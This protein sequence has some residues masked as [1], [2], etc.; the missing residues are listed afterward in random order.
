MPFKSKNYLLQFLVEI[1]LSENYTEIQD[2]NGTITT[3][4]GS[5]EPLYASPSGLTRYNL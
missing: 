1:A 2:G 5:T 4:K 3:R